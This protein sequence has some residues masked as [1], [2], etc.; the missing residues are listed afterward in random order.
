MR[1][2]YLHVISLLPR[3]VCEWLEGHR[4]FHLRSGMFSEFVFF[5]GHVL[6]ENSIDG[7]L[8]SGT[9]WVGSRMPFRVGVVGG[10]KKCCNCHFFVTLIIGFDFGGLGC[11]KGLWKEACFLSFFPPREQGR[12]LATIV[13]PHFTRVRSR[14]EP[15]IGSARVSHFVIKWRKNWCKR[16][17]LSYFLRG[18]P[19]MKSNWNWNNSLNWERNK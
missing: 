4:R 17:L 12:A 6:I 11:V 19:F 3:S 7:S 16:I 9:C 8:L 13:T 2:N 1:I 10:R 14:F 5:R 18:I 15:K